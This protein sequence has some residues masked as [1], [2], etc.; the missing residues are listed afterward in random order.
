MIGYFISMCMDLRLIFS[1]DKEE[2]II[3]IKMFRGILC[4]ILLFVKFKEMCVNK[5]LN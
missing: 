2:K 1:I 5:F 3:F 4:E